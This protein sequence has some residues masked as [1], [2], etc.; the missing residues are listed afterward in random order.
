MEDK[1]VPSE[2]SGLRQDNGDGSETVPRFRGA[3]GGETDAATGELAAEE[4][5]HSMERGEV[6]GDIRGTGLPGTLK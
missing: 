5:N 3:R 1:E 2:V 6:A 4:E